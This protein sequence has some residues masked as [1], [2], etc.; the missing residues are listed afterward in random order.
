ML[1]LILRIYFMLMVVIAFYNW[2]WVLVGWGDGLNLAAAIL[3]TVGAVMW[4]QL[5]LIKV[6]S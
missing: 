2:F 5:D 3:S 6:R 1:T 4:W